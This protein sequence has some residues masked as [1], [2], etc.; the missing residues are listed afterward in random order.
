[1][2][3]KRRAEAGTAVGLALLCGLLLV[4][5]VVQAGHPEFDP[6]PGTDESLDRTG[7]PLVI[8]SAAASPG[9]RLTPSKVSLVEGGETVS[10]K[11]VLR[12]RPSAPVVVSVSPDSQTAVSPSVL[13]FEP[14][15]WNLAQEV[16][17]WAEDDKLTE[18]LHSGIVTHHMAS[19]GSDYTGLDPVELTATIED[20]DNQGIRVSPTSLTVSEPQGSGV[21]TY[22]LISAPGD[23]VTIPLA[24]SNDECS[25]SPPSV[26]LNG[27]N[28]ESGAKATVAAR[29]DK[30]NDGDQICLIQGGPSSS[31]DPGYQGLTPAEVTV[32]VLDDDEYWQ[33]LLPA[34]F[35]HWP[36]LPDTPMLPPIDNTDSDGAY[37]VKWGAALRAETYVLEEAKDPGFSPALERYS[38]PATEFGIEG[39]GAGRLYYRVKARNS[40]GDSPWSM[41]QMVDVLWEAEPNQDA[42]SLTNGPLVSDL[43]Y[44]GTFPSDQDT[45][46]YYYF[47]Q[48]AEGAVRLWLQNIPDGRNYDLVLRDAT[49]GTQPGWYSVRLGNL[50]EYVEATIPAGRYHI[51]IHNASGRGSSQPYHLR[52]QY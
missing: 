42:S 17:V 3:G 50:D 47:D 38:G 5:T 15:D 34:A 48:A 7:A 51:Q 27:E 22:S 36:P 37:M 28:W 16:A 8:D 25:V 44:Y 35:H 6:G 26:V 20:N 4:S 31:T 32:T 18:G 11:A 41:V 29:D 14:G 45:K 9:L 39:Q 1:M 13:V 12:K 52:V 19:T 24:T 33:A 2:N 40:W 10:Y 49:L 23:S 46:D 43:V 21:L 30:L